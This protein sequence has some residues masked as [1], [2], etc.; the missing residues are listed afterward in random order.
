[1]PPL[2][3]NDRQ[4]RIL[5]LSHEWGVEHPPVPPKLTRPQNPPTFRNPADEQAADDLLHRRALEAAQIR[6]KSG[7][8][9]AFSSNNLKR[10]KNA[11]PKELVEA[12]SAC[13]ADGGSPGVAEALLARL[14]AAGIDL[15]SPTARP[16]SAMLSRR[17]SMDNFVDRSRLL[18]TAVENEQVDMLTVLLPHA[19]TVSLDTCLP[20]AVRK[21]NARIVELLLRYG[22]SL[23]QTAEGQD[24][25]RQSALIYGR[26]PVIS[27]ILHSDGRPSPQLLSQCLAD[28]VGAGDLET[29]LHLSR[30]TAD[31]NYN[32]AEPLKT[33][34]KTCR[35]DL[36]LAVIMGNRP[37]QQ[38]GVN[39]AFAMLSQNV[40]M[41][42]GAKL[43]MVE[44][45]LCAGAHGEVV[46]R[47]LKQAWENQ[48]LDM[49]NLL[50][51]YG[52]SAGGKDTSV[53]QDAIRREQFTLVRSL[54]GGS[55]I[56]P[57][58]A[59][60]CVRSIP[61]QS[62]P[63]KRAAFL[64]LLLRA[65][66]SG[67]P[68]HDA[69]IDAAEAKDISCVTLLLKPYFR[70]RQSNGG[71]ANGDNPNEPLLTRHAVASVD[72]KRGEALRTAVLRGDTTLTQKLLEGQPSQETLTA[73]FPS[74]S[75]LPPKERYAMVQLFLENAMSGPSLHAALQQAL[76]EKRTAR[77]GALIQLLLDHDAD[78]NYK[79]GEGL[80]SIIVDMDLQ[81]LQVLLR[82]ASP[83]TAAA[84]IP[85]AMA[86]TDH[87]CR[88][89]TMVLLLKSGAVIGV[90]DIATALLTTLG[91]SPVDISLLRL[92]L[93][94]GN[95]DINTLD[96]S[97][98]KRGVANPDPK[99]LEMILNLGNP[100]PESISLA[101]TELGSVPSTEAKT[102]KLKIIL[103]KS[104]RKEDLSGLLINEVQS[105]MKNRK[106]SP[107]FSTLKELL[108]S[109]ADP[110][111]YNAAAL[112]HAV[113]S[114]DTQITDLL[115]ACKSQPSPTS[116]G[117]ALPHALHLSDP[118]DRLTFTKKLVD[119]GADPVELNRA[120]AYA[121]NTYHDDL[122]LLGALAGSADTSDGEALGLAVSKEAP[123]VVNILLSLTKHTVEQRDASV[124][125]A[126]KI[127]DRAVRR[128]ICG[129]LLK[130]GT[131]PNLAS[132]ALLVAARDGDLELSDILMSRGA[133]ISSSNGQPIIE[134]CRS[135][136]AEVLEVLLKANPNTTMAT[137]KRGFQ[138]ATE[139][140]DLNKRAVIF[141][142]LL[143]CGVSGDIVHMQLGSATRFGKDGH[144]ILRI[145]LGAGADPNFKSGDA[146]VAATSSAF[147]ENLELLLGLWDESKRQK[148]VSPPTLILALKTSWKLNP[149]TRFRI[150]GDLIK[151]GLPVCED[152]HIALND[153]V[154]EEDP[155][156]RLIKLL[157]DHG[158][159]PTSNGCKTLIDAS[160]R[161]SG[162]SLGLLLK[163]DIPSG[164]LQH[165]FSQ[166]F[167]AENVA[168]WFT[169][170][171]LEVARSFVEKGVRGTAVSSPLVQVMETND[172]ADSDLRSQFVD[173]LLSANPDVNYNRGQPLQLAAS[174]ANV[175]WTSKLL[176]GHPSVETLSF[177]FQH[178]FDTV[179]SEDDALNLFKLFA[180]YEDGENRIDVT[181]QKPGTEPILVRAMRQYPRKANILETLL[182]A[183][184]YHDQMTSYQYHE[185]LDEPEEMT[186]LTWAIAQPQKRISPALIEI[187]LDRGGTFSHWIMWFDA[188]SCF[189]DLECDLRFPFTDSHSERQCTN[190]RFRYLSTH[191]RR[192]DYAARGCPH[193]LASR[194]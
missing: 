127:T 120:L 38:P 190:K 118:M 114:S 137:L 30:S 70:E 84:R 180:D 172:T 79:H 86:I 80:R 25:L 9:R 159:S 112:H 119:A 36:A 4:R 7:L 95:A 52:A 146:V 81:L 91:E 33:A 168:T 32:A 182:N 27:L 139:V 88:H 6:P 141:E 82:R 109:G 138:A 99:V 57:A 188:V 178:I 129:L 45:L 69:L 12:L 63:E 169:P 75:S 161:A 85:D 89:D 124:T 122:S 71:D 171:G 148:K 67:E 157:L 97:I 151:A 55:T 23:G 175:A 152:L 123:D 16:K 73:V 163:R 181:M 150:I 144:E 46:S 13:V 77:D 83:Q 48:F 110:N 58:V 187:L 185:D 165:V 103:S 29:V 102:W 121:I 3:P 126:L 156:S 125:K 54:M 105:L 134:A 101:I 76:G 49:A 41:P 104:A 133:T 44:L 42:P 34:V 78:I 74:T 164:D 143:K 183:G 87:R 173:L 177:A 51:A 179:L 116:L 11:E 24:A 68:L 2:T 5:Q 145:L 93:E 65:G 92:L 50:A 94:A 31:G 184:C 21:G 189:T 130:A 149:D 35:H 155:E 162:E 90:K 140:G 96:G 22:A 56:S 60:A 61:K 191:G 193:A 53:L 192:A 100:T 10:G 158:A 117:S 176:Q 108:D 174:K 28:A 37:P 115:F 39:D 19:D 166:A 170:R 14:S 64:K 26:A 59:S 136:S 111:A 142:K 107:S 128:E 135:G 15:G 72:H 8:S 98:I 132:S 186:L 167:A 20:V 153:A 194:G 17:K 62:N 40:S 47:A 147:V 43:Q 160:H 106:R 66:A 131:S 154:S 1:M 113:R 18:R